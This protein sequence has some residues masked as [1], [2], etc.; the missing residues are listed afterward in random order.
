MAVAINDIL[1]ASWKADHTDPNT[2]E[3]QTFYWQITDVTLGDE[4]A[5]HQ[6]LRDRLIAMYTTLQGQFSIRYGMTA[7]RTVNLTQRIRMGEDAGAGFTGNNIDNEVMPAQ[8]AALVVA[9]GPQFGHTGRKYMGPFPE[10]QFDNGALIDAAFNAMEAFGDVFEAQFNGGVTN[11]TY[12]PGTVQF[13]A[14]PNSGVPQSFRAFQGG[15]RTAYRD[16]RTQR[17]RRPAVGLS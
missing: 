1:A 7:V 15:L 8:N 3:I 17:S 6:D 16:A 12:V 9:R 10:S 11:N 13:Q 5:V 2:K 14:P 4:P